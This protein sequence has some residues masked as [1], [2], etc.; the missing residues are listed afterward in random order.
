MNK[1]T[2]N[3]IFI[4]VILFCI[5][6]IIYFVMKKEKYIHIPSKNQIVSI[7]QEYTNQK[8]KF[9]PSKNQ[10][11]SKPREYTHQ[12]KEYLTSENQ[13]TQPQQY[14][15]Q[16]S[17][18]KIL[19]KQQKKMEKT[20][21]NMS[22][23]EKENLLMDIQFIIDQNNYYSKQNISTGKFVR[24]YLN[25]KEQYKCI[26]CKEVLK[27]YNIKDQK[28][29]N[30][31]VNENTGSVDEKILEKVQECGI[32]FFSDIYKCNPKGLVD[33]SARQK[34]IESKFSDGSMSRALV[35]LYDETILK[36]LGEQ[37]GEKFKEIIGDLAGELFSALYKGFF[38]KSGLDNADLYNLVGTVGVAALD[39]G[40]A[41]VG[42]GYFSGSLKDL[43]KDDSKQ[44]PS[45]NP[46][47]ADQKLIDAGYTKENLQQALL[48]L[49]KI[50]TS[51]PGNLYRYQEQKYNTT[52][53][54]CPD[55]S[56]CYIKTGSDSCDDE[57]T[58]VQTKK[59]ITGGEFIIGDYDPNIEKQSI[60]L[61]N[62]SRR[63]ELY[64]Y[65][66]KTDFP[67]RMLISQGTLENLYVY[68]G[69]NINISNMMLSSYISVFS[70]YITYYEELAIM[71]T[72]YVNPYMSRWTGN[73][74][75]P[76]NVQTGGSILGVLQ[77]KCKEFF[78]YIARMFYQY[79]TN[80]NISFGKI[81][82]FPGRYPTRGK[83]IISDNNGIMDSE[84]YS[85]ISSEYE[86]TSIEGFE[87][88]G[89]YSQEAEIRNF[90]IK[91]YYD[92]GNGPIPIYI[93]TDE[94]DDLCKEY[95]ITRYMVLFNQKLNFPLDT[96][97][98][99]RKKAGFK[100]NFTSKDLFSGILYDIYNSRNDNIYK[101]LI[102]SG[103]NNDKFT[104][105]P[106][107][108]IVE[109]ISQNVNLRYNGSFEPPVYFDKDSRMYHYDDK[110]G[111]YPFGFTNPS[112]IEGINMVTNY[113][114]D[115]LI[116]IQNTKNSD[117]YS[118]P[119]FNVT[120][121]NSVDPTIYNKISG[122]IPINKKI[123]YCSDPNA[124]FIKNSLIAG[125]D[126]IK[127]NKK[128]QNRITYCYN[129]NTDLASDLVETPPTDYK[130]P[131]PPTVYKYKIW[132]LEN[133]KIKS[134]LV[135][136]S[137]GEYTYNNR[138]IF[139]LNWSQTTLTFYL[140]DNLD[141]IVLV[142]G[143][144]EL[145]IGG[146]LGA[147]GKF[148]VPVNYTE[149]NNLPNIPNEKLMKRNPQIKITNKSFSCAFQ[150]K[151]YINNG[152]ILEGIN[153]NG[154]ENT[155]W[156]YVDGDSDLRFEAKNRYKGIGRDTDWVI[157][158][159][160]LKRG[161]Q[162]EIFQDCACDLIDSDPCITIKESEQVYE[163]INVVTGRPYFKFVNDSILCPIRYQIYNDTRLILDIE[164]GN[165][166]SKQGESDK[167]FV[168]TGSNI[169]IRYKNRF[170]DDNSWQTHSF[171]NVQKYKW[172]RIY[173]HNW[174]TFPWGEYSPSLEFNEYDYAGYIKFVND[175]NLCPISYKVYIGDRMILDLN[176]GDGITKPGEST[177]SIDA[178]PGSN[179]IIK[180]KNRTL[181]DS[182]WST[183]TFSNF[184]K[185]KW[186]KVYNYQYCST[187]A[188]NSNPYLIF[189]E[190]NV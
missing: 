172:Y 73:R 70:Y 127:N 109:G 86:F 56:G 27:E 150:Y 40:L 63:Q 2:K 78:N 92:G 141:E 173:N 50:I 104:P 107:Y 67:L 102:T 5:A 98:V 28:D 59:C 91:T 115:K 8:I 51:M 62:T 12:T 171:N 25:L 60:T 100:D 61:P 188:G 133:E 94:Y 52:R 189:E 43:F 174:C 20:L 88:T 11:I 180:Y 42:L 93:V 178:E 6:I 121:G 48:D 167:Y 126:P 123:M 54:L 137:S 119:Y 21:E 3:I 139:G 163:P 37:G 45:F 140:P 66:N 129:T 33:D 165:G 39:V 176:Y 97:M 49:K 31:W 68:S 143:P 13:I 69:F 57:Q 29:L 87:S 84:W 35:G 38:D 110:T 32:I 30:K 72:T 95:N 166:I 164:Y 154:H 9:I 162:Y 177:Y 147:F 142:F 158:T 1:N 120:P 81:T 85:L 160:Y 34:L 152:L 46:A 131:T 89:L 83:S 53:T 128:A 7:P 103:V 130:I 80:L 44:M 169:T 15:Q 136:N 22:Y 64:D 134:S 149:E 190:H 182:Y 17:S 155:D 99:L 186:Y 112:Y 111:G 153:Y 183:Y 138:E 19:S 108:V 10:I 124:N 14:I 82:N 156:I 26:E 159:A 24:K 105:Q 157:S 75:K 145:I 132:R 125:A 106:D 58:I 117:L 55:P 18:Y 168:N 135:L 76:G 90:L 148:N 184:Q 116:N 146:K 151:V 114:K 79:F 187:P 170:G 74:E 71:D 101:G 4:I 47:E 113:Q 181:D 175:S 179:I 36:L 16:N 185:N 122:T 96:L 144:N 118:A 77:D 65:L 23:K 161:K 41:M